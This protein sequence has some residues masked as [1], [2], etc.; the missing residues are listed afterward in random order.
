MM[1]VES[2]DAI[3]YIY[4]PIK[5]TGTFRLINDAADGVIYELEGAQMVK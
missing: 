1:L 5:M 2:E 3:E 4:E